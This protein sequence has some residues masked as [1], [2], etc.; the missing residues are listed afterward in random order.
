MNHN[1]LFSETDENGNRIKYDYESSTGLL[2]RTTLPGTNQNNINERNLF[3]VE[4]E[5]MMERN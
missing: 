3:G 1:A 4:E 2:K 5:Y